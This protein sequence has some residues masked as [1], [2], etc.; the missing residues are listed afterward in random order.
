MSEKLE[1]RTHVYLQPPKDYDLPPHSCGNDNTQ[2]SEFQGHLWC[3]VCEKD[4]I[5]S[6]QGVFGGPIPINAAAL[7]GMCFDRLNLATGEIEK[8]E[9]YCK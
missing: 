5:P 9:D 7:M 4:F 6:D 3:A 2:W 8:L 1:R